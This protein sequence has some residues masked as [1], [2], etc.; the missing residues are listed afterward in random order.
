MDVNDSLKQG[1]GRTDA[2]SG[3]HRTRSVLVVAE[4]ASSLVLLVGAGSYDSQ[5]S[6]AAERAARISVAWRADH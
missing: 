1:L 5:L 2:E 6:I 3:G 4:V